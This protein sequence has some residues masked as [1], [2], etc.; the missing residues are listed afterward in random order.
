MGNQKPEEVTVKIRVL[1]PF[2]DKNNTK[3]RYEVG[4][5]LEFDPERAADVVERELAEYADPIG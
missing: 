2:L 3:L 4:I 5:E 1:Q